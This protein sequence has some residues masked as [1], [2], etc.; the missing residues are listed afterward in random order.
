MKHM[1]MDYPSLEAARGST[2]GRLLHDQAIMKR[3]LEMATLIN[4]LVLHQDAILNA[5]LLSL[6][7]NITV[8]VVL[9]TMQEAK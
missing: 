2:F 1:L 4:V 8:R 6:A 9:L 7:M 5:K 3:A